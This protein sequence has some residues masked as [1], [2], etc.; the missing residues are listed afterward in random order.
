MYFVRSGSMEP[1]IHVGDLIVTGP[2]GGPLTESLE[3]GS[4]VTYELEN[5]EEITHRVISVEAEETFIT[6]GD[7]AEDPDQLPVALNQIQGIYIFKVP[8]IGYV[9]SFIQTKQ[10]WFLAIIIPAM[11]LVGLIVKDIVKAALAH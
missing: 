7:A 3:E 8:Y 5:G 4:I 10:G 6:Q 11:L 1:T 2:I 9:T